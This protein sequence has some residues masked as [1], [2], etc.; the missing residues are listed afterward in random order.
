VQRISARLARQRP[1]SD[2][3]PTL[4]SLWSEFQE[5]TQLAREA[6]ALPAEEVVKPPAPPKP[7]P[8]PLERMRKATLPKAVLRDLE[9]TKTRTAEEQV[10][11]SIRAQADAHFYR[12]V[13]EQRL[14]DFRGSEPQLHPPHYSDS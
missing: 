12:P 7:E 14:N 10:Y 1:R 2:A 11:S 4:A 3:P 8:D 5:V 9:D 13:P 6:G